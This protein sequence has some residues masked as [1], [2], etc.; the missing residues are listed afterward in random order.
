VSRSLT[1]LD[2]A[3]ACGLALTAV[4]AVSSG[5]SVDLGLVS[6]RLHDW[7]RPLVGTGLMV[8]VRVWLGSRSRARAGRLDAPRQLAIVALLAVALAS[9]GYWL[10]FLTTICGG[11]DSYGYVSASELIGRGRLIEPQPIAAWLPVASPLDVATPAGYVPAADR[12]GI[13]PS[14]PL[15]LPALM[16][17]AQAAAGSF[18]PYLVPPIS[19]VIL[20]LLVWRLAT[21]WYGGGAGWLAAALVAWEALVVTYAKQPMSDVPATMFALLSVWCLVEPA[22]RPLAA[23]LAAGAS[24]VTRPGGIGL[25]AVLA[26]LAAWRSESRRRD[27]TRFVIG[28]APFVLAQALLQWRLFGSPFTSGY[29]PVTQLFAGGTILNNLRIYLENVWTIH[30]MVWFAGLLA[31]CFLR[32][33]FPVVLATFALVVSAIPYVLYFDF[34]HWETLRFLLPALVLCSIAAAGGLFTLAGRL[35]GSWVTAVAMVILAV[36]PAVE[37]E[38][39]LRSEGVPHLMASE[40]RYPL[41]AA[42]LRDRTAANAVVLAAQHSGSI[43]HYGHRQTLRWDLLRSE[44]LEPLIATLAERGHPIYL[45]LEGAEQGRFTEGFATPLRRVRMYPFGQI[46]N[47]QIWELTK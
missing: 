20:L 32:P 21:T 35:G 45:V 15:G 23:G 19:G 40:S 16:A 36:V 39:F 29:G 2:I 41:V 27:A 47:V 31:A 26:A 3:I 38:R 28:L 11:S 1:A 14:Y 30:S 43:R 4:L 9:V 12:S 17:I 5:F 42:H 44:E 34:D 22:R 13:A 10:V 6:L 46:R 18:G 37:T 7:V 24:F 8:A 33:R 25:I